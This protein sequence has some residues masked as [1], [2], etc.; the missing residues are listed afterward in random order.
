MKR[1]YFDHSATTP[2]AKEVASVMYEYMSEKFGNPSSVHFF[3]R[4]A[5]KDVTVARET[6]AK[7]I[8]AEP[9]ELFF[10]GCGTEG[11]NLALKGIAYANR[12]KGNHIITSAV[13]HHAVLHVCEFLEKEGF[14]VTYLQVDEFGMVNPQDVEK[15]ITDQTILISIMFANNEVGTIQPIKEIGEIAKAKGVYFHTDDVQAVGNYPIDVKDLNVD[16]LTLS[17]H[18][19]NGPKG[20]GAL[21]VRKGVKIA[22]VQQ[23]GAQERNLRAGTENVPSIIGLAKAAEIAMATMSEKIAHE[24]Y[25]RDKLIN[26]IKEKIGYIKLNGHPTK[27][28]PNNVNFSFRFVEGEALLLS[29]DLKGIAASSGSACTSGSLDPS[30]VLLAMGMSHEV[31][32]GSLRISLGHSNTEEEIDYCLEVL[33]Q[34][35]ERLRMMSPLSPE[36][37]AIEKENCETCSKY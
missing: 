22:A 25:L 12:K 4:E 21:Y 5:R 32:H 11:D 6:I 27:R 3:G 2:T 35:I 20:I 15:A 36:N 23:G 37:M 31:A 7:L 30:H 29:L 26:G 13:E 17:G 33:P 19:F 16:L 34:I 1:I 24:T 9:N 28:M 10:M 8:G 18:K 14:A